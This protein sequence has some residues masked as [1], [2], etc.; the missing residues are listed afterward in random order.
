MNNLSVALRKRVRLLIRSKLPFL[1][2]GVRRV[3]IGLKDRFYKQTFQTIYEKNAWGDPQ[4]LSGEGSNLDQTKAVRRELPKLAKE[5]KVN[6]MLDIPCGDFFWMKEVKLDLQ[7]IG[8]DIV[9]ALVERN[10]RLYCDQQHTF[11]LLDLLGDPLPRVDLIFCRDC[12]VHFSFRSI[13]RALDN[14]RN[15]RST[16][17]LTTTFTERKSNEDITTG[18][19]RPINL[20]FPPFNFPPPLLVM[21]EECPVNGYG[22][23]HLGL[24]KIE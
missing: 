19:W 15:S 8:G 20:Q 1:A 4:S 3:R 14:M 10:Q 7:Y 17:L 23:K 18:S 2:N 9:P 24:W 6:S 21:D 12:F 13:F 16:Y 11:A 22:D 5:L